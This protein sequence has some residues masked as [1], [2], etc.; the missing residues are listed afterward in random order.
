MR[1]GQ[2]PVWSERL[3]F[4]EAAVFDDP[5]MFGTSLNQEYEIAAR[6]LE[7][8]T[9]GVADLARTAVRTS[10]APEDLKVSLLTEIDEYA[11][12]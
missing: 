9:G 5:S 8:D 11:R 7:L 4:R 2:R 10:F 12:G 1:S 3:S 6:L